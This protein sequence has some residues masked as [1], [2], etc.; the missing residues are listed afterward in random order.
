MDLMAHIQR[1]REVLEL[2]DRALEKISGIG[3]NP[4][5]LIDSPLSI[6]VDVLK[7]ESKIEEVKMLIESTGAQVLKDALKSGYLYGFLTAFYDPN[8]NDNPDYKAPSGPIPLDVVRGL[9]AEFGQQFID[10]HLPQ[11]SKYGNSWK[12]TPETP[13]Y[14]A[15]TYLQGQPE[16]LYS[17]SMLEYL[18]RPLKELVPLPVDN[19]VF[20]RLDQN[21]TPW[22][23]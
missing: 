11:W 4:D 12:P 3:V 10:E 6:L 7:S 21:K 23:L 8:D 5:N 16:Y 13:P 18:S 15:W 14:T 22:S 20:V 9:L 19:S 2:P 1:Y 17:I